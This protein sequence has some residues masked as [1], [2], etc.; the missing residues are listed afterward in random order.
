VITA[1]RFSYFARLGEF[2]VT[3]CLRC[4]RT[5]WPSSSFCYN[6][7]SRTSFKKL[8]AY[9]VIEEVSVSLIGGSREAY[10][11]VKIGDI[12]VIGSLPANATSGEVVKMVECGIN[13]EGCFFCRFESIHNTL[14]C[15][16]A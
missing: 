9:G 13:E 16:K 3:V 12:R 10:G 2:K 15:K 8:D 4:H 14:K 1:R 7:Y 5:I 11:L 6:C